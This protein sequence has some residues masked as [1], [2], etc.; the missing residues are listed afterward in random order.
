MNQGGPLQVPPSQQRYPQSGCRSV[1]AHTD[2]QKPR[3][4]DRQ[5]NFGPAESSGVTLLLEAAVTHNE[6][7]PSESGERCSRSVYAGRHALLRLGLRLRAPLPRPLQGQ[8]FEPAIRQKHQSVRFT[9]ASS[10]PRRQAISMSA[11][12]L[13]RVRGTQPPEPLRDPAPRAGGQEGQDTRAQNRDARRDA[14]GRRGAPL[15]P[16]AGRQTLVR[17]VAGTCVLCWIRRMVDPGSGLE[18]LACAGKA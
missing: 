17:R 12:P 3:R 11:R 14:R 13:R 7:A 15:T 6:M 10:S 9:G 18:N 2:D 4:N 16:L 1:N 8:G 5:S